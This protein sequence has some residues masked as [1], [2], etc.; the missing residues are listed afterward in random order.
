MGSGNYF[1]DLSLCLC[2]AKSQK[3]GQVRNPELNHYC[4]GI[5][6]LETSFLTLK[7]IFFSF[8]LVRIGMAFVFTGRDCICL[9]SIPRRPVLYFCPSPSSCVVNR[10]HMRAPNHCSCNLYLYMC[11]CSVVSSVD[12]TV[13]HCMYA[14][15]HHQMYVILSS[16]YI[17]H[18]KTLFFCW[19]KPNIEK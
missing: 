6:T 12:W 2:P 1:L 3:C 15:L 4:L 11:L 8:N 18:N 14:Y 10:L 9:L 5:E 19:L 7:H 13:M 16:L 17:S